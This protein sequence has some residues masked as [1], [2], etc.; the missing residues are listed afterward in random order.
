MFKGLMIFALT[1]YSTLAFAEMQI[2]EIKAGTGN[3]P[4]N[5]QEEM[6][7]VQVGDVLRIVNMDN[8]THALHTYGKPCGHS[9]DIRPGASWDC[10]IRY[11]Y[12][13]EEE[14]PLHDHYFGDDAMFW[15]NAMPR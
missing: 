14:G 12:N 2:F 10:Q 13:I 5:T 1:V 8:V 3:Q 15:L 7:Q 9:P 11:P 6:V 4:W